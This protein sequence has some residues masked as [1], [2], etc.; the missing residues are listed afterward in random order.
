MPVVAFG[1]VRPR[2]CAGIEHFIMKGHEITLDLPLFTAMA[3]LFASLWC[4]F[5]TSG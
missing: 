4:V 2:I 3:K 5:R 1:T